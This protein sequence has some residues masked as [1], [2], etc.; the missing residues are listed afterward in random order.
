MQK[1][2]LRQDRADV[3]VPACHVIYKIMQFADLDKIVIPHVGL[4]EGVLL[5]MSCK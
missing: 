3:I 1:F 2:R 4:R 5:N